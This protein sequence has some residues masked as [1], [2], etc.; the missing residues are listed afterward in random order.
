MLCS[1][2]ADSQ[3]TVSWLENSLVFCYSLLYGNNNDNNKRAL[4]WI[5]W[6]LTFSDAEGSFQNS[7]L[8]RKLGVVRLN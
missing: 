4:E 5:E 8:Y 3:I 6:S 7:C 2:R 1:P